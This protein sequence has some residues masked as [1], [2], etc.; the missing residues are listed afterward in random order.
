[1]SGRNLGNENEIPRLSSATASSRETEEDEIRHAKPSMSNGIVSLNGSANQSVSPRVRSASVSELRS[2]NGIV[3]ARQIIRGLG[4][5]NP[6]DHG[7]MSEKFVRRIW[8]GSRNAHLTDHGKTSEK[9]ARLMSGLR[10]VQLNVARS[11]MMLIELQEKSNTMIDL[12]RHQLRSL[13]AR[14]L[15]NLNKLLCKRHLHQRQSSFL[16]KNKITK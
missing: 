7:K 15:Q 6:T 1:L 8:S 3:L 14:E 5:V 12:T 13:F 2:L 10:N 16:V 4:N 9:F 11:R